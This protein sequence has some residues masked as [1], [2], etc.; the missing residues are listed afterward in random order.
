MLASYDENIGRDDEN[1]VG[2]RFARIML[3]V[4]S[5]VTI[6]LTGIVPVD[7]SAATLAIAG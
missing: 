1:P 5:P 2:L 7:D 6:E 4:P 3:T